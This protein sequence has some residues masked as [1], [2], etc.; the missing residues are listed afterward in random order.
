MKSL[1]SCLSLA[2]MG[3]FHVIAVAEP[4]QQEPLVV[5]V[6][7]GNLR[8]AVESLARQADV[9]VIYRSD[10]LNGLS[11]AGVQG[12]FEAEP[13][14]RKLLEGTPLVV[15]GQGGE[16]LLAQAQAQAPAPARG[17]VA[18]LLPGAVTPAPAMAA[19][20]PP[21]AVCH[22]VSQHNVARVYC[23]T[24]EQW[25]D[26]QTRAGFRCRKDDRKKEI[27]ASGAE[28]NRLALMERTRRELEA[29]R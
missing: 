1:L 3:C 15:T 8:D 11:T 12:A 22:R 2:C 18:D 16:F 13:A 19:S 5:S 26:L 23:G 25:S 9:D 28:W 24:A 4:R 10:A 27:C 7:A 20:P 6:P 14:F 21:D 29:R 17:D